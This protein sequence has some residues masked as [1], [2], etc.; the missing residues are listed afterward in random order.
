MSSLRTQVV[1]RQVSYVETAP[2]HRTLL[3]GAVSQQQQQASKEAFKL[4]LIDEQMKDPWFLEGTWKRRATRWKLGN[5]G[6]LRCQGRTYVPAALRQEL[7]LRYHNAATAGHGGIKKTRERLTRHYYWNDIRTDVEKHVNECAICGR[8]KPRNHRPYGELAALPIP[9][10]PWQTITVDFVTGLPTSIDPRTNKPCNAVLVIVDK[11]TKY[12]LYVATTK[13]LTAS[14]FAHIFFEY[15]YRHFGLPDAIVSDRGSLFTSKF[16]E[17]ICELLA[18]ERRLS[19]AYHPQ[20]DGQTERQNQSLEHYLRTYCSWDQADWAQ[21]L[22]LAEHVY[23]NSFHTAT[24][25]T[26]AALLYGYQPRDPDDLAA[27]SKSEA[28]AAGERIR[29]LLRRRDDVRKILARANE[30]YEKWYNKS[31]TPMTF[32]AEDWVWLSS[33]HLHQKRPSSKLADKYLG[34][35]KIIKV[36]G[37]NKMAYQ[38][39]LPSSFKTHTTF[40]IS[41]LEPFKGNLQEALKHR[42]S[43]EVDAEERHY[44]VETI[45]GHRGP[46]N[47][48]QFLI[49]WKG[50]PDEDNSWEPRE[51]IDNGPMIQAYEAR[52]QKSARAAKTQ[53]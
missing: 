19:T 44:D 27:M 24:K 36:V 21:H 28:P 6:L 37:N 34:P 1:P 45:L 18:I 13:Q 26:P 20:T 5:D 33:K 14:A 11:F 23:N 39:D 29:S 2:D 35:F 12:A 31:R 10:R 32:K 7:L 47:Q 4:K 22:A 43:I 46:P 30:G 9:E 52:I 53:H 8:T 3:V 41:L 48:R 42:Q 15:M 25:A 38:L 16:W 40:P 17:T 49:K 51:Y 50:Y